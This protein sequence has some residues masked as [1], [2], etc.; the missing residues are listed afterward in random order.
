[1]EQ[2]AQVQ[3]LCFSLFI[4]INE[5]LENNG[6]CQENCSDTNGSFVC[7]CYTS[8]FEVGPDMLACVGKIS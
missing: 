4:D 3:T 7:S 8:G 2:I 5:C 6:R 1:M